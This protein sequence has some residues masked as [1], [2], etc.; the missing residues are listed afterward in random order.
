LNK[1]K[2]LIGGLLVAVVGGLVAYNLIRVR[3]SQ[4]ASAAGPKNAPAVKTTAVTRQDMTQTVMAP[5]VLEATGTQEIR[6][7][8][9]T[10]E[11]KLLVGIGEQVKAGQVIAELASD[12]QRALVA[13][14]EAAVARAEAAVAQNRQRAKTDPI[15]LNQKYA[16]ARANLLQ[17][18]QGL[19]TAASGARE[20]VDQARSAL[21]SVLNRSAAINAQVETARTKLQ[22]TENGYRANPVSPAASGAYE[23]ARAAYESALR[24]ATDSARQ[25]SAD[26]AQAQE[27][28]QAAEKRS[29]SENGGD[30][31]AVEQAKSTLESARQAMEAARLDLEEG[32]SMAEQAHAGEADLTSARVS[33]DVARAKL[34]QAQLKA[35]L[36]GVI[37]SLSLKDGQPAQENQLL[38]E[39]GVLDRLTIR[40]RADEVDIGKLQIGQEISLRSNAYL[41]ERF[42]GKVTRVAAA[43]TATQGA[44]GGSTYYEVQGRI[45][46]PEG[47][48]KA[49]MNGEAAIK[50]DS[51]TGAIVVGLESLREDGEKAFVLVVKENKIEL[52]KVLIGLRTQTQVEILEGL[53]E[54]EQVVTG[55]FTFIRQAKDGQA[56]RIETGDAPAKR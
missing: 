10:A 23:Q 43:A 1:R 19:Q 34:E 50:T 36:D 52:R 55:P 54:G 9:T 45:D 5:G 14:Q 39:V 18:E 6:A 21:Q 27:S 4:P 41:V 31:A 30:P 17:A 8:F 53:K 29:T 37:L 42:T 13:G 51:R 48:L 3:G 47:K 15:A 26:L 40:A 46:N 7:P 38:M 2:W 11:V 49:G 28:L 24:T 20:Q 56:V 22:E 25:L 16:S 44:A 35:P 32:G 33:L 12:G